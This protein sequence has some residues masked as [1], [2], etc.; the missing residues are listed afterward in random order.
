[1]YGEDERILIGCPTIISYECTKKIM[2]QMEKNICNIR[3]G[4]EL[5]GTGFF[6]KIPF[7]DENNMLPVLITNHHVI[8]DK[9]LNKPNSTISISSTLFENKIIN[10]N[11][12]LKDTY[13]EYD[14]TIIEINEKDQIENYLEFD[15]YILDD[16]ISS[17]NNNDK[18]IEKTIYLIQYPEGKLSVSYGILE[19][20]LEEKKYIFSHKCSTKN[21]SS[22][23]PILNLNNKIIGIHSKGNKNDKIN[24]GIFLN[25]PIKKFIELN[26][27]D[28]KKEED[29]AA[30]NAFNKYFNLD[31]KDNKIETLDLRWKSKSLDLFE[32]TKV[33]FKNLKELI[34]SGYIS[35]IYLFENKNFEKLEILDLKFC[36]ITN[37]KSFSN[38][39]YNRLKQLILLNNNISDLKGLDSAK[40]PQLELLDLGNNQISDI[41]ILHKVNFKNLKNLILTSNLISDLNIFEKVK[42]DNLEKLDLSYNKIEVIDG[43][44]KAN[45]KKLKQLDLSKNMI[46]DIK[47]FEKINYLNNLDSIFLR[48]NQIDEDNYERFLFKFNIKKYW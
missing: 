16:I 26:Y 28:E 14:V 44:E 41:S 45:F 8:N 19:N 24:K 35:N 6:C 31:L 47:Q 38:L 48:G 10:L 22:G 25:Y 23:S 42:F 32:L 3:I 20:I 39:K 5:S 15:D 18:Y 4:N 40:F 43:L 29:K 27:V 7:P 9:L 21:G 30:L 2:E 17:D 34:I 11:D 12:R 1:M 46:K 13:K 33:N 37:L 36:S